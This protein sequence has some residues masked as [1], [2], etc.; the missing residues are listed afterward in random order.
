LGARWLSLA[1]LVACAG[2]VIFSACSGGSASSVGATPTAGTLRNPAE[3]GPYAVGLTKRTFERPS[4][5]DGTPRVM[6]T[7]IW[8]PAT[9]EASV[10][11][12][13]E[14][15]LPQPAPRSPS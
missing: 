1:L 6:E 12:V 11:T 9:G 4:N 5:A 3:R 13:D 14:P 2:A 7:S 15:R 8:Y 10:D